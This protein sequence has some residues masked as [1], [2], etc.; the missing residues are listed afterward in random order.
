MSP[1]AA[2]ALPPLL[3]MASATFFAFSVFCRLPLVVISQGDFSHRLSAS[4]SNVKGIQFGKS[5]DV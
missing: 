5:K 2:M 3:L 1:G 4:L